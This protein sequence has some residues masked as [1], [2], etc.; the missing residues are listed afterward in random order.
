MNFKSIRTTLVTSMFT[1]GSLLTRARR[2]ASMALLLTASLQAAHCLAQ[3]SGYGD[4]IF[5]PGA[6]GYASL[7][8][9]LVQDLNYRQDFSAEVVLNIEASTAGGR[10]PILLGKKNSLPLSDPGFAL[11]INQGQF[12]SVGQQL[13]ATVADGSQQAA[14]SSRFFQGTVHAVM[15]WNVA[16]KELR[17]YVNGGLEG[18]TVNTLI[19]P[20]NLRS[21]SDLALTAPS[22]LYGEPAQKDVLLARLWNRRLSDLEVTNLWNNFTGTGQHTLPTGFDRSGL[23]SEWLMQQLSDATHLKDSQGSNHLQIQGTAALWQANGPLVL[24]YPADGASNVS[25]SVTLK[26]AGGLGSLGASPV[27]PL[28]YQLQ[29][30]ETSTFNSPALKTSPWQV[31]YGTWKPVLKPATRYYWRAQVRDSSSTATPSG[32]SATQSFVTK[33]TN[34]WFVRPAVVA[35]YIWDTG[36]P[37]PQAGVYGTQDGSAYNNAWNGLTSVVWGEGGVEAGDS[38]YV[39][40]VHYH[41]LTNNNWLT[42][43]GLSYLTESGYSWDY[44]VTIRMDWPSD[45]GTVWGAALNRMVSGGGTWTGPDANGVYQSMDQPYSVDFALNG[46]NMVLLDRETSSTWVGHPGASYGVGGMW[47]VKMPDGGS[48]AGR[49][50][51][52]NFGYQFNLGRSRYIR[53]Y[54]CRLYNAAPTSD[55]ANWNPINDTQTALPHASY[56]TFDGCDLRYDAELNLSQGN[57]Y[58]TIRNS[59]LSFGQYGVYTFLNNRPTGANAL[60]VQSNYIHDLGTAR[61]P[62]QD[63]HAVG[64]QGGS[65]HLIRG[66]RIEDT[67]SAIEFW[68]GGYVP[69]SNHIIC[70]NFIKNVHVEAVTTGCG[71]VFSADNATAP[72]GLRTGIKIYGN[73]I[74][75]PGIGATTWWDGVGIDS[76]CPDAVD[77]W[78]NDIYNANTG[79]RLQVINGGVNGSVA[80]NI[81]VNP[82]TYY[83]Y[84]IANADSTNLLFD[85]NLYYPATNKS[86]S[87]FVYAPS[88][89]GDQ[90]SVFAS[91]QFASVAAASASDFR[92]QAGSP[93]IGAGIPVGLQVDFA[94]NPIS[95]SRP[96][97]IG[98]F[99]RGGPTPPTNLHIG[100]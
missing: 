23:V 14:V 91:P 35:G 100:P 48:P 3:S 88:I 51:S 57:D 97:D 95:T 67:G 9:S 22:P 76:G 80:N 62:H 90:H 32:Y 50:A 33:G 21:S 44:P 96:P 54:H 64:V 84:V 19:N 75:N 30:D 72:A 99:E 86:G 66:N 24:Q 34:N 73:I 42:Y 45:P 40:G 85:Y 83:Y 60:T 52:S 92:I 13:Y 65:G 63:G 17:L 47:F 93:A 79:M 37:I 31:G 46:T 94:G 12:K 29:V 61:F 1:Q 98:A 43:Q 55:M 20:A 15:T 87:Q 68:T 7:P 4:E 16:S 18:S 8:T 36:V 2:G 10:W 56:I 6:N 53:F 41:T 78:N 39:C 5:H 89:P 71:I 82:I 11:G 74:V 38:L 58:W 81:I 27:Q 69:Q 26:V 49:V 25:K 59:E 70:Y 28:Q 77:I